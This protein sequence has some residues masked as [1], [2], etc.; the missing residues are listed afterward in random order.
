MRAYFEIRAFEA[1]LTK[2]GIVVMKFWLLI[3][4]EKQSKLFKQREQTLP[5]K[6]GEKRYPRPSGRGVLAKL[7]LENSKDLDYFL[8]VLQN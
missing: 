3:N 4:K 7:K 5:R 8:L 2:H 6:T 1:D